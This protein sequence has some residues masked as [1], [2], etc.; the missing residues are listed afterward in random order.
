MQYDMGR[1]EQPLVDETQPNAYE[2]TDI[3]EA[4][5]AHSIFG[6]AKVR[7]YRKRDEVRRTVGWTLSAIAL[8][9]GA[10]WM[11]EDVSRQPGGAHVAPSAP[12]AESIP[13]ASKPLPAPSAVKPRIA[14]ATAAK[15]PLP[16]L[17]AQSAVA[18][19]TA[20]A[21]A[22]VAAPSYPSAPAAI[23]LEALHAPVAAASAVQGGN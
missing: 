15:P 2:W 23:H 9:V 18:A 14:P 13:P 20:P 17:Q 11:I 7:V 6:R 22:P 3:G 5:V 8:V 10:V 19:S 12:A 4:E 1:F 21:A 16:R